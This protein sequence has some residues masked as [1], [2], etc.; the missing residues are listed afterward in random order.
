MKYKA[1]AASIATVIFSASGLTQ[2]EVIFSEDF[3]DGNISGW[4]SSGSGSATLNQYAGNYS[5][6]VNQSAAAT[7]AIS[8]AGYVD[9]SVALNLAAH[10]LEASD[11]CYAQ[12]SVDGGTSWVTLLTVANG[13]DNS[14]FLS[15]SGSP[16]DADD[17]SDFQLRVLAAGD[18]KNDYCYLDNITVEGSA[19]NVEPAPEITVS[20]TSALGSVL[21]G[22]STSSVITIKNDGD[23]SLVLG[24]LSGLSAP[25][26]LSSDDC[27]NSTLS[28]GVSCS[29]NVLFT[30]T[31]V[32]SYSDALIIS[33]NDSDES[34]YSF[35]VTGSG[36][37]EGG[38]P[39]CAYDCLSGDGDVSRSTVT[40]SELTGSAGDGSLVDFSG[41]TLPEAAA[42]P[43]NTFQGSLK[44]TGVERG[45]K[46][47]TDPHRY[48]TLSGIKQLPDF[49]YTFVQHGTHIIPQQRGLITSA[50]ALGEWDLILEPG[51]VWDESSDN[52][53][54]RAAMPFTL[55]EY[56]Q[57]CTHNGVL[58]F[59]F[60]DGGEISNVQYQVA[61][62]TC[63]YYQFN[64]YGRLAASYS[65]SAVAGA[66]SIK[67][68][69]ETEV[70]SRMPIKAISELATD[71]PNAS[72]DISK[73]ASDQ[74]AD[75]MTLYGVVYNGVHYVGGC[76]TRYGTYP[77]CDVMSLPSYS[78]AK[79]V[80]GALS[81]MRLQQKYPGAKDAIV[82]DYVS[83][84]DNSTKWGSVT[85]ENALDMATGNYNS[86]N[87]EKDEV[88]SAVDWLYSN[89]HSEKVDISCN[90][91]SHKEDAGK[92]WVYH[93]SDSYLVGRGVNDYLQ[94]EE[95]GSKEFFADMLVADVFAPLGLSPSMS[96][97]IRTT[98][99][100]SAAL[101]ALGL[102]YHRDD[103]VKLAAMLNNDNGAINGTQVLDADMVNAAL[104]RDAN[105][106]GLPLDPSENTPT[107][108]YNDSF[109]SYDLN[110]SSVMQNC[111]K[112][113]WVP[114]MSG[115]GGIGIQLLPNG[116][117]YYFFSD[118][119]D[120]SFTTTTNELDKI[121]PLCD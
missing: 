105:D 114:Y 102:F 44:F 90:F 91:Y 54:S 18:R 66:E 59:L 80:V 28:A 24:G 22:A 93:S 34:S 107:A 7:A 48:A 38:N 106:R 29:A 19:G 17:N 31:S 115:Y 87:Y 15:Y 56:N 23:A 96:Q 120:F 2:A 26:S 70:S 27:S 85:L 60:K 116:M 110:A 67:S 104:Q 52:G 72:V 9:V 103:V 98:D 5:L 79:S 119:S 69:Y 37:E 109:W 25:F 92:T 51:R 53:Y 108:Y 95:G 39:V 71:Y 36:I 6:R 117:T 21:L 88:D 77:F 61:S 4:T 94:N 62:E 1:I 74:N 83:E 99:S 75:D 121:S 30:P 100:E 43:S 68:A 12:A 86:S 111:S 64:L 3:Q 33:S 101:T 49:D 10:S 55:V 112:E 41:F 78:T 32:A 63:A 81:L 65:E 84:C 89:S 8:T 76:E 45:W 113:T 58:S 35:D 118:G 57:N 46:R 40:Y 47:I 73:I 42:N 82:K 20:G 16:S 97:S 14:A 11:E 50:S 13:N